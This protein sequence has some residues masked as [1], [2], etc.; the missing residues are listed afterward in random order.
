MKYLKR[1]AFV[2]GILLVSFTSLNADPGVTAC[3]S[4]ECLVAVVQ[5]ENSWELTVNCLGSPPEEWSG[6]GNYG[7]TICGGVDPH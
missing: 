7:G 1:L 4:N 2:F 6:S 5:Y 3:M